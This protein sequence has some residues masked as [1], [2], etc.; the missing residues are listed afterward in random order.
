MSEHLPTVDIDVVKKMIEDTGRVEKVI[1]VGNTTAYSIK[2]T[3]E[4]MRKKILTIRDTGD[5]QISYLRATGIALNLKCI[6]TVLRWLEDNKNFKDGG[7]TTE[8]SPKE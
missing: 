7:F 3:G 5:G 8:N 2:S 4:S 6:D 1:T